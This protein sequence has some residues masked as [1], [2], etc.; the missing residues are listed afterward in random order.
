MCTAVKV[1]N[2]EVWS[3]LRKLYIET[4]DT[5]YRAHIINS[6]GCT[7]HRGNIHR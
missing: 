5:L 3:Y 2:E 4:N 1:G 6:M 7:L